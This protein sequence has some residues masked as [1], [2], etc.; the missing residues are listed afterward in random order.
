MVKVLEGF[1]DH[2][3]LVPFLVALILLLVRS[4]RN[5]VSDL[6]G[7]LV[8]FS[9]HGTWNTTIQKDDSDREKAVGHL[10]GETEEDHEDA[11]LHQFFNRVWGHAELGRRSEVDVHEPYN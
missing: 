3:L 9:I 7:R 5:G 2:Y 10:K 11:T 1:I 4:I 6:S 8:G